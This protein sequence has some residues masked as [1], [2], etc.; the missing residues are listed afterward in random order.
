[1]LLKNSPGHIHYL[2][3][4]E[5]KERTYLQMPKKTRWR[6][7]LPNVRGPLLSRVQVG[8]NG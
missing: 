4:I 7:S 8:E 2:E 6:G 5:E 3:H 1:M